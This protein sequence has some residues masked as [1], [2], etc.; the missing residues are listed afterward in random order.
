MPCKKKSKESE[1]QPLSGQVRSVLF[2]LAVGPQCFARPLL[3]R[4]PGGVV[5]LWVWGTSGMAED[6]LINVAMEAYM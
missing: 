6:D 1:R 5:P 3:G 2:S 4:I